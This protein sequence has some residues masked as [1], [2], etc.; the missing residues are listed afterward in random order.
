MDGNE[1]KKCLTNPIYFIERYCLINDKPIKLEDYQKAF[2]KWMNQD[3]LREW[4]G[5]E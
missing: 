4:L 3:C 5:Y 1:Y 2:I